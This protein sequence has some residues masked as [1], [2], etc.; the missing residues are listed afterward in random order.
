ML[1][2]SMGL[3]PIAAVNIPKIGGFLPKGRTNI[4]TMRPNCLTQARDR[5][6]GPA[7]CWKQQ[8]VSRCKQQD[9]LP[10][11][12]TQSKERGCSAGRACHCLLLLRGLLSSFLH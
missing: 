8:H 9:E 3:G 1:Q 4:P 5:S 7:G 10:T 12:K 11:H 2:L 6:C